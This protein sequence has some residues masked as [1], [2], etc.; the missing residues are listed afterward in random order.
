[1]SESGA[2]QQN[3]DTATTHDYDDRYYL[4]DN[5]NKKTDFPLSKSNS[6]IN[7]V[8]ESAL[9][10]NFY[11]EL[12]TQEPS[13]GQVLDTDVK[14]ATLEKHDLAETTDKKPASVDFF[15]KSRQTRLS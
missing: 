14:T 12:T 2:E 5:P 15:L 13:L 3:N 11:N 4:K 8:N 9:S 10:Q 7:D 6:V 1:M